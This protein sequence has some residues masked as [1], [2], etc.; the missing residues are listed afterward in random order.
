MRRFAR[1]TSIL[2]VLVTPILG[3]R[4]GPAVSAPRIEDVEVVGKPADWTGLRPIV[5]ETRRL[6]CLETVSQG[7]SLR[8]VWG[9]PHV[10]EDIEI[11]SGNRGSP[12]L[13]PGIVAMGCA[14][15]SLD[16]S[17][18]KIEKVDQRGR[19]VI[20]IRAKEGG[21]VRYLA[22][23]T[24]LGWL[25]RGPGVLYTYDGTHLAIVFPNV[26]AVLLPSLPV[27]VKAVSAATPHGN[28]AS[29]FSALHQTDTGSLVASY[30]EETRRILSLRK[31]ES[32]DLLV[33]HETRRRLQ[34]Q[35]NGAAPA[36]AEFETA[37]RLRRLGSFGDERIT[38]AAFAAAG[39]VLATVTPE[40]E[41]RIRI[42]PN[43]LQR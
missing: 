1:A 40:G 11:P 10:V 41:A 31:T 20:A 27:P 24:P 35:L 17:R 14:R 22:L 34:L 29:I 42:V 13:T 25:H 2:V 8:V 9:A 39:L 19:P 6:W 32:A 12:G 4:E 15:T 36:W 43:E 28:D 26:A 21:K 18:V 3:C 23:G 37:N 38:H 30:D 5:T 33:W 16:G 7:A